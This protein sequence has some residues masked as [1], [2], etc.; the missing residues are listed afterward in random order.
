MS[1][2]GTTENIQLGPGRLYVA[3]VGTAMPASASAALPSGTFIPLGYT[4][5]GTTV[6]I[7]VTRD[8]INVAEELD[9]VDYVNSARSVKMEV[10][11]AEVTRKRLA[12][13]L[14]MG[15]AELDNAAVLDFPDPS[16]PSLG[17]MLVWDSAE[18]PTDV[19]LDNRRWIV[20][21]MIPSGS[22]AIARQKSPA[23]STLPLTLNATKVTG[24]PI[25]RVFPNSRGLV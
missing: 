2:G 12:L 21:K 16:T 25:V 15:T 20:P 24:S 19:A 11:L 4:E 22:I 6:T 8:P 10:A 23:K 14:A 3:V 5:A 17:M 1:A 9:P 18:D 13:A 7:E